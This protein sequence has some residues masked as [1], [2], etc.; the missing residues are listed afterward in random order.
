MVAMM[1]IAMGIYFV[2]LFGVVYVCFIA[3]PNKSSFVKYITIT[4]PN[5]IIWNKWIK[6]T[7]HPKTIQSI[8]YIYDRMLLLSYCTIVF[9][10]WILVFTYIFPW[11]DQQTYVSHYH[12]I[13]GI[14]TFILCIVSW[15]I[16]CTTSPGI[17]TAQTIHYYNHYPYD[18][19]LYEEGL[20]CRT[21][22][23]TVPR[24]ARS[25]YDRYKYNNNIPRY[26]HFCGWV[27]NTIGEEN[28]RW[29][30]FFLLVHVGML[31]YGTYAISMLMY[32]ECMKH[33]LLDATFIDRNT[34]IEIQ[35]SYFL[36]LQYF[37]QTKPV[38]T[39]LLLLMSILAIALSLFLLYHVWI[40]SKN[41]TTNEAGK[42]DQVNKWYNTELKLY[43]K[44]NQNNKKSISKTHATTSEN[45]QRNDTNN[46]EKD[47][48][49]G[50]EI[51]EDPGPRPVN[52]YDRGFYENWKEVIFPIS[53]RRKRASATSTTGR[54]NRIHSS[55]N[56][57]SSISNRQQQH[58][59]QQ[60]M[61][62]SIRQGNTK[63]I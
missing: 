2:V 1:K 60:A 55:T 63:E 15:R 54:E 36:L 52:I 37:F 28:Y 38:E 39:S 24:L 49:D 48:N 58:Q 61:P 47:D 33:Q 4:F 53:L 22:G 11:I 9:G 23:P 34:G 62:N 46:N 59:H 8:E 43:Q 45:D 21:K 13:G 30:L 40:T 10:S 20:Y 57:N 27:Y 25:K 26:D 44:Q 14:G 5:D 6:Q 42:W 3:D 31:F 12:K 17:I 35:V 56:S 16:A 32:N 51:I 50:E 18:H 19:L 7:F 29:F 41:I